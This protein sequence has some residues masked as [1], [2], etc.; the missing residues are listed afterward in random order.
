[1]KEIL[2]TL[3]L[4]ED[5]LN[6]LNELLLHKDEEKQILYYEGLNYIKGLAQTEQY[7]MMKSDLDDLA[8]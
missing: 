4:L 6:F 3:I 7:Q 5:Q 2:D 1:M 8:K